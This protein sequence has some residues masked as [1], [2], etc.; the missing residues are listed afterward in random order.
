MQGKEPGAKGNGENSENGTDS[1]LEPTLDCP[2]GSWF[3]MILSQGAGM[4]FLVHDNLWADYTVSP[5]NST[6]HLRKRALEGTAP[7][8]H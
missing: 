4:L 3:F 1:A 6:L 7:Q 8:E 2:L 5:A